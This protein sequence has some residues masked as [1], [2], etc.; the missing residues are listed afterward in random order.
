[1]R[2]IAEVWASWQRDR[3]V[4]AGPDGGQLG[5]D[6]RTARPVLLVYFVFA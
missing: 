1:M 3:V 5:D 2:D 4:V 6:L